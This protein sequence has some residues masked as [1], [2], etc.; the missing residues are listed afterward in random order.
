[1]PATAESRS[2]ARRLDLEHPTG[3]RQIPQPPRPQIHQIHP[4]EQTRRRV[5]QQDLTAVPG[6]HHPRSTIEHRTEI[7]PIAQLGFAGRQPHPHRQLQR[8]LRGHR[9]INR[10]LGEANAAHTPSPVCLN[11]QP[12]CAP[13]ADAQHLVM[14]GHAARI[15]SA[16]ASH[17][18]VEPSTSVKRNV[19]T[20]EGAAA[21]GA[22]TPAESHNRP[23]P[24]LHIAGIRPSRQGDGVGHHDAARLELE[25]VARGLLTLGPV[26]VHSAWSVTAARAARG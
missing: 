16:S 24:T 3:G 20:P 13:I 15:A 17:R 9:R 21:A 8:P 22:D 4:A 6:G 11:N 25:A 23:A 26:R 2:Q 1:M 19:T 18:R 5:G 10:N 14:G 12:P 7:V